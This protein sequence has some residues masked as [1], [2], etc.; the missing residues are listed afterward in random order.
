MEGLP[1]L[2]LRTPQTATS[3]GLLGSEEQNRGRR[4]EVK[5]PSV[6]G[7]LANVV[8]SFH[9]EKTFAWRIPPLPAQQPGCEQKGGPRNLPEFPDGC[10]PGTDREGWPASHSVCPGAGWLGSVTAFPRGFCLARRP[11][12]ITK[13]RR[14]YESGEPG[15]ARPSADVRVAPQI[16][17]SALNARA[18]RL[19]KPRAPTA[20]PARRRPR[21]TARPPCP[22]LPLI[23]LIAGCGPS[24]PVRDQSTACNSDANMC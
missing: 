9:V 12:V 2:P 1:R 20:P 24:D 10:Q 16:I 5:K 15:N 3:D 11:W 18:N 21:G 22:S 8:A 7:R 23:R 14:K 6:L 19:P 13:Y 17:S 4:Q